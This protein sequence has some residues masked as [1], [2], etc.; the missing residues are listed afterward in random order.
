MNEP[1]DALNK[2]LKDVALLHDAV[3][4]L[5]LESQELQIQL[6]AAKRELVAAVGR[7][8]TVSNCGLRQKSQPV[9]GEGTPSPFVSSHT[10]LSTGP[11]SIETA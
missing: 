1:I 8:C 4:R 5:F 9:P 3:N 6:D 7:C 11:C 10:P 2:A